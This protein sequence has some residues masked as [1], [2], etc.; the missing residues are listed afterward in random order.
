MAGSSLI[1][2]GLPIALFI[3]MVGM[4]LTLGL[5]DFRDV[6]VYPKAS[7][8]GTLAQIVGMP[9]LAFALAWGLRLDPALAV[10]LVVIAACPGGTTSNIFTYFARG[11]V[12]L[13][14]VLTVV[15]SLITV[16]TLPVIINA[17]LELF[18]LQTG[19]ASAADR[20]SLPVGRTVGTLLA[21]VILPVAIGMA[22]RRWRPILAAKLERA[23]G[24]FGLFV[25]VVLIA[26]I[27]ARLGGDALPMFRDA[28]LAVALLNVFG[29]GLGLWLGRR[30]GIPLRDAVA[31]GMELGIKN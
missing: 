1:D 20:L 18:P 9:I 28:G 23:V 2:I 24:V 26:L 25:L 4:G 29:I 8:F 5:R 30:L 31:C 12:A 16:A 10:G 6:F 15:A 19:V 14:I 13:S 3:I 7:A 17:A 22:F 27:L 21:I 11:N